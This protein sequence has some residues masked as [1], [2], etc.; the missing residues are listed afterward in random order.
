MSLARIFEDDE[1]EPL[2]YDGDID[3]AIEDVIDERNLTLSGARNDDD[4]LN[5]TGR[6]SLNKHGASLDE[7]S[8]VLGKL[9]Y[10]DD[11]KVRFQ[12]AKFLHERHAGRLDGGKSDGAPKIILNISGGVNLDVSKP[13]FLNP[14]PK[15][16]EH[17]SQDGNTI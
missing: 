4:S 3:D 2:E 15:V 5:D 1:F 10:A 16:I 12:T 13:S 11:E 7:S 17:N 9:L 6:R 14:R 8:K